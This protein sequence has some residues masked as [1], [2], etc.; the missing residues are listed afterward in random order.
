VGQDR[1]LVG[2]L[3]FSLKDFWKDDEKIHGKDH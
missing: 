3:F 2:N 1:Y